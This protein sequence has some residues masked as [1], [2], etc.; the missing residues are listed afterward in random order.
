MRAG[1]ET[2]T[3]EAMTRPLFEPLSEKH[4]RPDE[5]SGPLGFVIGGF[6]RPS[7]LAERDGAL[8]EQY[9]EAA[10][11]LIESILDKRVA[12]YQ[13]A[14]AAL[15]LYRHC[16]ELLLKAG[17]PPA[18]RAKKDIH[19]LGNLAKSYAHHRQHAGESV[20]AWIIKR[21]EELAS[22]DPGSEAF[23]Y[24]DYGMPKLKDGSTIEDEIHV[25]LLHLKA[26]MAA[27]NV[28]LVEQ[29]WLIRMAKGER[30]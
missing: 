15:F 11:A 4:E 14:N 7:M 26:A 25:D 8:A 19:H 1:S 27:L 10:N 12:D 5:W 24:G 22:I 23:R 6:A 9:F 29:N 2:P 30:P 16:F 21:C 3:K 17:L 20:P 28:A 13:V 18:V